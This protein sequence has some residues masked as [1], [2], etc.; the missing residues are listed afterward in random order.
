MFARHGSKTLPQRSHKR[1]HNCSHIAS[2][3][4]V[5]YYRRRLPRPLLGE[6]AV[7]LRTRSFHLARHLASLL[8]PAFDRLLLTPVPMDH[9]Q[10]VLSRELGQLI[11]ADRRRHIDASRDRPV[12]AHFVDVGQ[13][14]HA[15]DLAAV[16]AD[17]LDARASLHRRDTVG[18][19]DWVDELMD[20]LAL[21]Q[22]KRNELALG[23]LQVRVQ[24]LEQARHVVINGV[25]TPV[26]LQSPVASR[27]LQAPLEDTQ[28]APRSSIPDCSPSAESALPLSAHLPAFVDLMVSRKMWTGQTELQNRTTY[29]MFFDVVGDLPVQSYG[30]RELSTFF[31]LLRSLPALYSKKPEWRDL[32]LS[33]FRDASVRGSAELLSMKTIKRHF[34]A[35]GKLFD[36]LK[37]HGVYVGPNPAH[38]FSFP[39]KGRANRRRDQWEGPELTQLFSSPVWQGCLSAS[40]R[41][42][43]GAEIIKDEKYWL[44]LLGLYHGNR[45]EEFAQLR[46]GDVRTDGGIMYLDINDEDGK[47]VKND[48]SKRRVPVHPKLIELGFL[49][50]ARRIAKASQDPLFPNLKPQGPDG[51]LG[52]SFTKWFTRYRQD[53]G[54][55]RKGLDYHSFRHGVTTKLMDASVTDAIVDELT[56]HAGQGTSRAVYKKDLSMSTLF[57]AISK[58]KWPEVAL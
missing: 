43:P 9:L 35:L 42:E 25:W 3:R 39:Q 20:R 8:D 10:E 27:R 2:K 14:T 57:D 22:E 15:A 48:Q 40:R 19:E 53:I 36:H 4:G 1:S 54:V 24:R 7:S 37:A 13:T 50:Y 41:T 21:P 5:L 47:Q 45:L 26:D 55:Y 29:R 38:E 28:G 52:T 12:Y 16:E 18:I 56:G 46:L 34:A 44:P 23:L 32:P 51:K 30:R 33:S 11:E 17:L 6:V 58:I 49:D 31:D